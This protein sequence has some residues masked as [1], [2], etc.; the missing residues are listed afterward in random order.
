[1]S[2]AA[3][4]N[5]GELRPRA[6]KPAAKRQKTE[7]GGG[8]SGFSRPLPLSDELSTFVGTAQMSRGDLTKHFWTYFKDNELQVCMHDTACAVTPVHEPSPAAFVGAEQGFRPQLKRT[9]HH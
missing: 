3:D 5:D 1:M 4:G 2:H 9:G 7:G 8:K 6:R